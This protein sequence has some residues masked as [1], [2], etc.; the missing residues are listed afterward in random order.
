MKRK[1]TDNLI[2]DY[3][4]LIEKLYDIASNS[5][6]DSDLLYKLSELTESYILSGV[7]T[8]P[9]TPSNLLEK[10][11][12]TYCGIGG[13][14]EEI[15]IH[16]VNNPSLRQDV[17]K[18]IIKEEISESV[19]EAA[20]MSLAKRISLNPKANSSELIDIYKKIVTIHS[21]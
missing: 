3:N 10:M 20:L 19:R 15:R 2:D 21:P 17:L 13:M 6:T 1:I 5:E 9:N 11:L 12:K 7:I 8:N 14:D 16:I 4:N 18:L